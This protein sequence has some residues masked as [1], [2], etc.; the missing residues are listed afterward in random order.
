MP[1]SFEN[2]PG[3][4]L[5]P[6]SAQFG[7]ICEEIWRWYTHQGEYDRAARER[8]HPDRKGFLNAY[9]SARTRLNLALSASHPTST[10][11]QPDAELGR[12]VEA[13]YSDAVQAIRRGVPDGSVD[14][15]LGNSLGGNLTALARRVGSLA[16][17]T[18]A[19]PSQTAGSLHQPPPAAIPGSPVDVVGAQDDRKAT[20]L[21]IPPELQPLHAAMQ[22]SALTRLDATLN[23]VYLA[24]RKELDAPPDQFN[25]VKAGRFEVIDDTTFVFDIGAA[26]RECSAADIPFPTFDPVFKEVQ[27]VY[28]TLLEFPTAPCPP[29]HERRFPLR[30]GDKNTTWVE[31]DDQLIDLQV[32]KMRVINRLVEFR[33]TVLAKRLPGACL[34]TIRPTEDVPCT[35]VP[36]DVPVSD[37]DL[38][39]VIED[40][41]TRLRHD[42][43]ILF[44]KDWNHVEGLNAYTINALSEPLGR[45]KVFEYDVTDDGR[46]LTVRH[47]ERKARIRWTTQ[48]HG[49]NGWG[50]YTELAKDKHNASTQQ[51]KFTDTIEFLRAWA[52]TSTCAQSTGGE[53]VSRPVQG[54]V[55]QELTPPESVEPVKVEKPTA[56]PPPP[57]PTNVGLIPRCGG[58][59][60][61]SR[62]YGTVV[63]G[64][65]QYTF[66]DTQRA[67]IKFMIEAYETRPRVFTNTELLDESGSAGTSFPDVFKPGGIRH[68]AW[69][70][71]IVP[72]EGKRGRYELKPD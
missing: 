5:P 20:P 11:G 9:T 25:E 8:E 15:E 38:A 3:Y 45:G 13:T 10:L 23:R 12:L 72:V 68:P 62:D 69:G 57:P 19:V 22:A 32:R 26:R 65:S 29:K 63:R 56:N 18:L 30:L 35:P 43:T 61:C 71:L 67:A 21:S 54:F 46:R 6:H 55:K 44:D 48:L 4:S 24:I 60:L 1:F 53:Q 47:P 40:V 17:P 28:M 66:T 2:P 14:W 52:S 50:G 51:P 16:T 59:L 31:L 7:R 70:E 39:T 27:S 64:D 42:W 33:H 37:C 49:M 34:P 41:V 36:D 58:R